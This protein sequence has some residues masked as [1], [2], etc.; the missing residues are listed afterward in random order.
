MTTASKAATMALTVFIVF[1]FQKDILVLSGVIYTY[2][3]VY[4]ICIILSRS[5]FTFFRPY[6][7]KNSYFLRFFKRGAARLET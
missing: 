3:E 1:P 4:N 2:L 5:F 6:C 7:P